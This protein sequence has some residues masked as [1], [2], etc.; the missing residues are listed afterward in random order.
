MQESLLAQPATALDQLAVHDTDLP[1]WASEG[2]E[3]QLQ[4]EAKR[5]GERDVAACC[6][7]S[8]GDRRRGWFAQS[9]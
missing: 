4:P 9:R 7:Q 1:G 5:F 6:F 2:D 3:A 8:A